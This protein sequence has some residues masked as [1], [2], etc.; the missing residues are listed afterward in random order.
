MRI[1]S[2][3]ATAAALLGGSALLGACDSGENQ[4][5]A[6]TPSCQA[7][8][9][10]MEIGEPDAGMSK[11]A[12]PITLTSHSN[13]PCTLKGYPTVTLLDAVNDPLKDFKQAN[14]TSSYFFKERKVET[15]TL[16]DGEKANFGVQT[17]G[18]AVEPCKTYRGIRVSPPGATG[19]LQ[20]SHEGMVCGTGYIVVPLAKGEIKDSDY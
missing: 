7:E 6:I 1:G 5:A 17:T 8:V 4:S 16:K 13:S 2:L 15:L 18:P 20:A 9:M 12:L 10:Q 14:V 19:Y 3:T 11:V